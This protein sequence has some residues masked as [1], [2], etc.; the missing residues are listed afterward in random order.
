MSALELATR[1]SSIS[2]IVGALITKAFSL[3]DVPL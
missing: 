1:V 2:A 3:I